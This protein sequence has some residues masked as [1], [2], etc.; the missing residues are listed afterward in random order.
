MRKNNTPSISSAEITDEAVFMNRREVLRLGA[1]AA[2]G[3]ALAG[4]PAADE[5]E[6]KASPDD[7][8]ALRALE[9]VAFRFGLDFALTST[10]PS[11]LALTLRSR[12]RRLPRWP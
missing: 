3:A 2:M 8:S 5:A 6:A 7:A 12:L 4:C 10:S 11:G 1:T 9:H